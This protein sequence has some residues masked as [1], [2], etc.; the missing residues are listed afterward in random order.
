MA[1]TSELQTD[2][3]NGGRLDVILDARASQATADAIAGYLDTE[4]AAI[5]AKTDQLTFTVANQV[6]ANAESINATAVNGAGT[7]G[8]KWRGA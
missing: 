2:W 4:V 7:S 8:N 3:A 6:D 5:K 1:D